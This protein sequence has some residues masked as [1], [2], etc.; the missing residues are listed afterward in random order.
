MLL[1]ITTTCE[2]ATDL[3]FLLHKHPDRV[4]TFPLTFGRAHVFYPEASVSRCTVALLV[5]VDPV[6]L[7]RGRRG[8]AGDGFALEQYVNDRPYAASSFLAVAIGEVFGTALSGRSA[9]HET[10]AAASLP[11]EARI[12]TVP[13][14]GGPVLVSR[15]FEP[16]GYGVEVS[17]GLLDA[18]FPDWGPSPYF[19]VTLRGEVRLQE[20]LQHLT[21]LIPVL[22]ADK[23]YWVGED[24]VEKLLRRGEGWLATHPEREL[25]ADRYLKRRSHLVRAALARLA[26]ESQP[27]PELEAA[28]DREEEEAVERPLSLADQRT[29][30]VL[31]VLRDAGATSVADLGCGDGRLLRALLDETRIARIVGMD[32]SLRALEIAERRLGLDR[33]PLRKRERI[34]LL[35][36]SLTYR[37]ERLAGFD[38]LTLTEVIE[39]LDPSRLAALER[40]VFEFARPRLVVVTTPNV[41]F[42]VRFEN[43]PAGGL[44]HRDHRF[45]WSRHEFGAWIEAVAARR[46][47]TAR[48]IGIGAVDPEVG[49]PT[50]M[51]I[52]R[53]G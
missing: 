29:G 24:E 49:C 43:L 25:I 6:G 33:L 18:T 21:V 7:V 37:D 35:H 3:G 51:G 31:A 28:G 30:A 4:Q 22:D 16:L 2:P 10:L 47:Y 38:A 26:E 12:P 40:C 15:L 1:T 53:R 9:R 19:S 46:G 42:N 17:D 34:Q 20:L 14:R 48:S 13:S 27:E 36:G 52:F 8:P 32:A 5:D 11:L 41:E 45:E 50:Q 44:R 39:H 23:H